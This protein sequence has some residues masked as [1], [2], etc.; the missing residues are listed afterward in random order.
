MLLPISFAVALLCL[1]GKHR[2]G[3]S[4]AFDIFGARGWGCGWPAPRPRP[5]A[6]RASF[7]EGKRKNCECSRIPLCLLLAE[8]SPARLRCSRYDV[9]AL[10]GAPP[11]FFQLLT[12]EA[13]S[14]SVASAVMAGRARV[15]RWPCC[16]CSERDRKRAR[17][18]GLA[19]LTPRLLGFV[20]GPLCIE[21]RCANPL[22]RAFMI[23]AHATIME[24]S[25]RN[26]D[27]LVMNRYVWS[28]A[29]V[30]DP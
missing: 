26:H 3:V 15:P 25:S 12:S 20:R 28:L 7:R 21:R 24:P 22:A 1:R 10:V 18:T 11:M 8:T 30:F 4:T 29:V 2:T 17:R 13:L 23:I 19:G 27:V 14:P 16:A 6:T 9:R 5:P